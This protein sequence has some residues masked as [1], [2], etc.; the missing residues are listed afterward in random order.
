LDDIGE[1]LSE[2]EHRLWFMGLTDDEK[3]AERD[4][5]LEEWENAGLVDE[6]G[7]PVEPEAEDPPEAGQ[8]AKK[9]HGPHH[10]VW[11]DEFAKAVR[12][13]GVKVVILSTCNA[14]WRDQ[15]GFTWRGVAAA[16]LRA[17]VPVVVGMQY[18]ISDAA[19][20]E[21]SRAFYRALA[22]GL[23]LD[24]AVGHGRAALTKGV[25]DG[26]MP[27]PENLLSDFGLPVLYTRTNEVQSLQIRDETRSALPMTDR[28]GEWN[29]GFR[30]ILG[31]KAQA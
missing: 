17:G 10:I 23:S 20:I 27:D 11:S 13:S 22:R 2:I 15:E 1:T 28:F 30:G 16:L 26:D 7:N 3:K 5:D 8:N 25:K 14:A 21:F 18:S 4:A 29:D 24:E 19:A 12:S 31:G 6:D 9:D